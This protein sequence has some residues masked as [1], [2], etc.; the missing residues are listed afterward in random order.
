MT[1][2]DA[3]IIFLSFGSPFAVHHFVQSR[4]REPLLMRL[5]GSL[6]NLIFWLPIT[7]FQGA[8]LL[9]GL[10]RR[11][12]FNDQ[13]TTTV[14]DELENLERV[15][16]SRVVARNDVSLHFHFKDIF[17]RY[18]GLSQFVN[19]IKT[20]SSTT[21]NEIFTISAHNA[22]QLAGRCL[23]RRNRQRALRHQQLARKEFTELIAS[24]LSETDQT[25]SDAVVRLSELV[26]D[27]ELVRTLALVNTT[28]PSS[29]KT[30]I[31]KTQAVTESE[32]VI[33]VAG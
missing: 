23:A 10:L 9:S 17:L 4:N 20:D 33:S 18:S 11:M 12:F 8:Y 27:P 21:A 13:R 15:I 29:D 32:T 6:Y 24:N 16:A 28:I 5:A 26:Y 1:M 14:S 3:L 22:P 2:T 30:R 7:L 31:S 19:E 25:L